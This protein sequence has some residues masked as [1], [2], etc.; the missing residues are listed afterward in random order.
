MR[1]ISFKNQFS[2]G[3]R[4]FK[5]K[6]STTPG[7][8]K[9]IYVIVTNRVAD[10]GSD[11]TTKRNLQGFIQYSDL[12]ISQL[13]PIASALDPHKQ[14]I[15]RGI[16]VPDLIP[17]CAYFAWQEMLGRQTI[18]RAAV[19]QRDSKYV[20]AV[21]NC[22]FLQFAL[23]SVNGASYEYSNG[24]IAYLLGSGKHRQFRY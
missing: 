8:L 7:T 4:K 24:G 3:T 2:R 14:A 1:K 11:C 17:T 18:S 6:D 12:S 10:Q 21:W 15:L 9:S 20:G 16:Q 13:I 19:L 5:A 22:I 23:I